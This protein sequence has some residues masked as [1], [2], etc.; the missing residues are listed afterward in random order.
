MNLGVAMFANPQCPEGRQH[1]SLS[2]YAYSIVMSDSQTFMGTI[3]Y[4]GFINRI[5]LNSMLESF[6]ELEYEEDERINNE[7]TKYAKPG[8][9]TLITDS[10]REVIC[11]IAM[12]H[13]NYQLASFAQYSKDVPLKIRLNKELHEILYPLHADWSGIKY[14]I[15]QG[16]YI[17]SLIEEY[18]RKTVFNR[19]SIYFKKTLEDLDALLDSAKDDKK[20]LLL[21]LT[22]GSRFII[23]PYRIS[24]DYEADYHYIVGMG[25][26]EGTKDFVPASYRISRIEKI[27]PRSMSSGSGKITEKEKKTIEQKIKDNGISYILGESVEHIIKLTSNGMN[28]YNSIFHQRPTYDQIQKGD[29]GSYIMT[30]TATNRQITNYFFTFANEAE[31]ISPKETREWIQNRYKSAYDSYNNSL[32]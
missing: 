5:V 18:A 7:I 21:T 32:G 10:E 25:A 26:K 12:A 8:R 17:K 1:I 30:F 22:N 29:N 27:A 2:N 14:N 23:K 24:Y 16:D 15:S 20:R 9:K 31:I 11:K 4:S 13:R 6:D 19:E 28:M 3:N